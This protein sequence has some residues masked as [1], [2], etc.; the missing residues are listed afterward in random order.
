MMEMII[1]LA[2]IAA[3]FAVILPQ[4]RVMENSWASKQATAEAIQNGRILV[5]YLNRN[6][7]KADRITAVSDPC[8]TTGY[9]E[10]EGN[11]SITYRCEIGADNIVE[12]GPVGSLVDLAGPVSQLQFTCYALDDMDTAITDV[13]SIR[14]VRVE[15]KLTNSAP[16]GQDRNFTASAY[17][18]TNASTVSGLIA[19]WKFDEG[20]GT[21]AA[22]ST[23]NGYDGTINGG[24]TWISG[25]DCP[26][27]GGAAQTALNFDGSNDYVIDAD[28]EN[29][30]NGL[31]AFTLSVWI[32]SDRTGTD[33]GVIAGR[34]ATN[35]D[36]PFGIRYDIKGKR[37]GGDNAIKC[38]ILV[39][40]VERVLESSANVQTT[41]WQHLTLTW[42]SGSQMALYIDGIKDTP[43]FN[44]VARTGSINGSDLLL[45]GRGLKISTPWD[46]LIDDVRIYNR[47]LTDEEIADLAGTRSGLAG[48]WGF[49]ETAGSVA[50]D[51]SGNNFDGSVSGAVWESSGQIDGALDFDGTDDYVNTTIDSDTLEQVSFCAWF[52]SDDA[53]SIG[54]DEVAQRFITQMRTSTS[55]RFALGINNNRVAV[56]WHDGSSNVEWT[57]GPDLSDGQW[58]HAAVTYDGS[59]IRLYLDGS[60]KGSF[61]ESSMSASSTST[62]IQIG[63]QGAGLR[64]F[65]GLLDD[66][67][68]Y[69]RA[70][71]E[72]EIQAIYDQSEYCCGLT[73]QIYP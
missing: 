19:H 41:N 13:D 2:L 39:S 7:A 26:W 37:A 20:S 61:S 67:R 48:C 3:I 18:R 71:T 8:D 49:D 53:G 66:V 1:S 25:D 36:R 62:N 65:D 59:D 6:L 31:T 45:I 40:G 46:G 51:S 57:G 64:C 33:R 44:D 73:D 30:I 69:H 16:L 28:G 12:F 60:E 10:F 5:N 58:Y 9:I 50:S 52:N 54:D 14:L 43:R 32:K 17:L 22:D 21:I 70:L 72:D 55:S 42:S 38:G 23:T 56:Y 24:A 27:M 4:F 34:A 47:V 68:I 63:R 11:D 15:T 29:Y 35:H